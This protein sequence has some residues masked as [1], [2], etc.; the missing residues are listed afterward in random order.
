MSGKAQSPQSSQSQGASLFAAVILAA[1]FMVFGPQVT[2]WFHKTFDGPVKTTTSLMVKAEATGALTTLD[3]VAVKDRVTVPGYQRG[4]G[5]GEAC[6][7]GPAWT[8]NTTAPGGHNGCSTRDDLLAS[9][10]SNVS[11]GT[12]SCVVQ[13]GTLNDPYTGQ[14]IQFTKANATAVQIDHVTP[15]AY[16]Y[17]MGA[18][19]WTQDQRNAFA[20]DETLNLVAVSGPANDTK[21]DKGPSQYMPPNTAYDCTYAIRWVNVTSSYKLAITPADRDTLKSALNTCLK[22]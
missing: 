22:G 16:A 2:S 3:W 4:C 14:T 15:L 10:M 9:S 17:D 5:K 6:S 7:F 11:K 12:S 21:S 13:S 20:N 19:G 18:A 8:D 1:L